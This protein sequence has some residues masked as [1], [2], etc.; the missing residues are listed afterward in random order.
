MLAL[1]AAAAQ[2]CIYTS[3]HASVANS[4]ECVGDYMSGGKEGKVEREE[5]DPKRVR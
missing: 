1:L 5:K 4:P 2:H 3:E